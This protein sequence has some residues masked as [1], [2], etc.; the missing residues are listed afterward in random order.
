MLLQLCQYQHLE[1]NLIRPINIFW[2]Q[3]LQ[4]Q[5]DRVPY[6]GHCINLQEQSRNN[7]SISCWWCSCC[8]HSYNNDLPSKATQCETYKSRS[9]PL[10]YTAY[11]KR[12]NKISPKHGKNG[13]SK[14]HFACLNWLC[15][16]FLGLTMFLHLLPYRF[17]FM[18]TKTFRDVVLS[19]ACTAQSCRPTSAAVTPSELKVG[20][21]FCMNVQTSWASSTS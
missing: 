9:L 16:P 17:S 12:R 6:N 4:N 13:K 20:P 11:I 2:T 8:G 14:T 19:A 3:P 15:D 18:R 5:K 10:Q 7:R 1:N 21:G